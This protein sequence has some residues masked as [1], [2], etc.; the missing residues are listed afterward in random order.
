VGGCCSRL[1]HDFNKVLQ[2]NV[3]TV[4][5]RGDGNLGLGRG[6]LYGMARHFGV[7]RKRG[8]S[9]VARGFIAL[10]DPPGLAENQTD[11]FLGIA[12]TA[13]GLWWTCHNQLLDAVLNGNRITSLKYE[14]Y[15]RDQ[16]QR[17]APRGQITFT[18]RENLGE[19]TEGKEVANVIV[20]V[21]R[22]QSDILVNNGAMNLLESAQSMLRRIVHYHNQSTAGAF[23]L[24]VFD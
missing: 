16:R 13:P 1:V 12:V 24:A 15:L 21:L 18:L 3:G 23:P 22:Y 5:V 6:T 8:E 17:A 11:D 2:Y 4:G 7:V 14:T 19:V 10:F 20:L 9:V